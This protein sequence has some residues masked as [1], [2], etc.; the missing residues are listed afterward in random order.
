MEKGFTAIKH[1]R[2]VGTGYFDAV[3]H[4]DPGQ[5][6]VDHGAQE[7]DRGRAVLRQAEGRAAG[8]ER[9][10]SRGV[11]AEAALPA[12]AWRG[13]VRAGCLHSRRCADDGCA[14]SSRSRPTPPRATQSPCS[15]GT[16][17][18]AAAAG[19]RVP[20]NVAPHARIPGRRPARPRRCARRHR[21]SGR[22][23][24]GAVRAHA[25]STRV[26]PRRR[27]SRGSARSAS[28]AALAELARR[29]ASGARRGR[30][31]AS[32]GGRSPRTSRS[33][34]SARA[35]APSARAS[36]RSP[37][38]STRC[39]SSPRSPRSGWLALSHADGMDARPVAP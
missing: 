23:R 21:R 25:R 18:G 10:T 30:G 14:S 26:L 6:G 19:R 31:F 5:P 34:A 29:W 36:P 12:Q 2:E 13:L 38:T 15:R 4:D 37:G 35:A 8:R 39:R 11:R 7:L 20:E 24:S 9:L 33:R 22:A 3:T 17:R 27:A 1:Q 16:S 28:P 32:S